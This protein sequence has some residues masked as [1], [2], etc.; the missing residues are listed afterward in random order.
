MK[1]LSSFILLVCVVNITVQLSISESDKEKI[2]RKIEELQISSDTKENIKKKITEV[3]N[4]F[5]EDIS[6]KEPKW[7]EGFKVGDCETPLTN[8][9][10]CCMYCSKTNDVK[11][12]DV[13][14]TTHK[15]PVE[16]AVKNKK[17]TV[18]VEEPVKTT[19]KSHRKTTTTPDSGS[20]DKIT[21]PTTVE[22]EDESIL[23]E[24]IVEQLETHT[25]ASKHEKKLKEVMLDI[26][27]SDP[28]QI[29]IYKKSFEIVPKECP[30]EVGFT[31]CTIVEKCHA[32]SDCEKEERCCMKNCVRSCVSI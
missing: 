7:C 26:D 10:V 5:K 23:P 32:N 8:K 18:E 9:T 31:G 25:E 22:Y 14:E 30:K 16:N 12:V 17:T 28:N 29:V 21:L 20:V 2:K 19:T 1:F 6:C 15:T 4:L 27:E 11:E 13:K 24:K 3:I